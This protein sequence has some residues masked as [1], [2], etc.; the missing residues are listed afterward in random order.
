M[1][2]PTLS[3]FPL[4]FSDLALARVIINSPDDLPSTTFDIVVVGGGLTG[5]AVAGRL[6]ERD[7]KLSVLVVEAGPDNRTSPAMANLLGFGQSAGGP[8]DWAWEAD[9]GRVIQG[10]V[11]S[12][13]FS[14]AGSKL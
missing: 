6:S 13:V 7:P 11:A 12:I 2:F 5:L 4:I 10:Y 14:Q 1:R 3:L 8:Q 9:G